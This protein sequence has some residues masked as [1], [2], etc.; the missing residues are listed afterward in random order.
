MFDT[1]KILNATVQLS[2]TEF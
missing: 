2:R 1:V